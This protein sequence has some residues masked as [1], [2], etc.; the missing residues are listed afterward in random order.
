MI[1][2]IK[3]RFG[4]IQRIPHEHFFFQIPVGN[5]SLRSISSATGAT[6][7]RINS[8]TFFWM[9]I[10]SLEKLKSI[11]DKA[12]QNGYEV[13]GLSAS[14]ADEKEAIIS[15]YNLKFDFFLA[16]EKAL[17]TVVRSNPGF[18]VLN[19]GTVTQKKHWNDAEDLE[20]K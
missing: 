20:F 8:R 9:L 3:Q 15:K 19:K 18:L 7:L 13:I 5:S 16:D 4:I 10:C 1:Q 12:L 17:K 14:G 2:V 6:S 11:S